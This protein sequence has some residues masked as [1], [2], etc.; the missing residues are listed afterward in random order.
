ESLQSMPGVSAAG[1]N[2]TRLMMGGRWDSSITL[3][4]VEAKD[5]NQPWSFFNAITPG[6]FQAL[7]IPIKTGRDVTWM[8][9]SGGRKVCL[10]NEALVTQYLGGANPVGRVMA[11]GARRTPDTE[12][13]GVFGNSKY[14]D[15][16]GEVPRQT[17]LSLGANLKFS[18]A[19]NIYA[20]TK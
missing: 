6:Y 4:G 18:S 19:I 1:A 5:G 20:R 3:P 9:W 7:D 2:T 11:Q 8:D 15:V 10:V 14:H 12:I 17:F 13:I 16:R